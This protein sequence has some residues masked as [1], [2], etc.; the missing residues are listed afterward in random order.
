MIYLYVLYCI[1]Y[2]RYKNH[3]N[4]FLGVAHHSELQDNITI[5]TYKN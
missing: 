2:I 5:S 4:I 3:N 1:I